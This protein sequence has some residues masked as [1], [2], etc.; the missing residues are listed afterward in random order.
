MDVYGQELKG[1]GGTNL[2]S[3]VQQVVPFVVHDSSLGALDVELH[4]QVVLLVLDGP[5]QHLL[6][7]LN[8]VSFV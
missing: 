2:D 1:K 7:I 4:D 5:N 6:K 8:E 3:Q